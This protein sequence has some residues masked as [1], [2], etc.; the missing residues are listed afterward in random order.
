MEVQFDLALQAKIDDLCQRSGCSATDLIQ[1]A[2]EAYV[3]DLAMTRRTLDSRYDDIKSGKVKMIP[4]EEVWT[5]FREKSEAAR[6]AQ[7][8]L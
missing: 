6:K 4:A 2:V 8:S 5:H 7:K 3:D 1:D